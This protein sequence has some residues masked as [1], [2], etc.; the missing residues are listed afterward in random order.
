MEEISFLTLVKAYPAFSRQYGEVS[1]VAGLRLDTESG[2]PEWIRL[3]PIP[4][5]T[6]EHDQQF[7]KYQ[8]I[9][10]EVVTHS[11]DRRPESRRPNCDSIRTTDSVLSS[12]N[13]WRARRPIIE[14]VIEQ[15]MCSL[16]HQQQDT[17]KSIGMFRPREVHDLEISHRNVSQEKQLAAQAW[18]AQPSLLAEA[19]EKPALLKALDLIPYTFKYSY[20]CMDP[21]CSGHTQTIVDWEIMQFYRR[22]RRLNNWP[23]ILR[24]KWLNELC[25]PERDTAFIV[26]NQHQGPRAFLVLGIWWPPRVPEQLSLP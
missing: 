2:R 19:S 6:L 23:E 9:S 22:V 5:R 13:G 21:D 11:G 26:G 18:A 16:L 20:V 25:G 10:L 3:Y 7:R 8:A 17:K 1:C 15:S 4:F 12:R 24:N 14:P